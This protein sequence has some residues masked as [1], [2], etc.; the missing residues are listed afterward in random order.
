MK[1]NQDKYPYVSIIIPCRNEEIFI[2]RCLNSVLAQDYP[3][4]CLEI[5]VVDGLSEDNTRTIVQEMIHQRQTVASSQSPETSTLLP[6]LILLDNPHRIVP[7]AL[8]IG[9]QNAQGDVI[10][11]LDGHSE[12]ASNYV[13]TC[14]SKL[15]EFPEVT[16]IGGPSIAVGTGVIGT[17]YAL[18]LQSAFGVG[19]K[20]FRTLRTARMVDTLAFGGYRREIFTHLGGF[21]TT[22]RRN[23]DI[24]FNAALR[25]AGYKQ[26]LIPETH[27]RYHAPGTLKGILLQ[28]YRN[29][30]WNTKVLDKMLGVLSWRHF[31]PFIFILALLFSFLSIFISK[32]GLY[33]FL[34]ICGTYFIASLAASIS[35]LTRSTYNSGLLLPLLFPLIHISYGWGSLRGIFGFYRARLLKFWGG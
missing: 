28:N 5:L 15:V 17:A 6:R 3:S 8:N 23:Q 31:I 20:T 33:L 32:W 7:T 29:G 13:R 1:T 18:A 34:T 24:Y 19:G 14:V 26:L 9:L 4:D 30:Y 10:F 11:R 12:M 21:D 2:Q 27:T 35:C 22:L 16:C 25:K